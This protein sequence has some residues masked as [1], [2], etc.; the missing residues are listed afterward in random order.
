LRLDDW[1][2]PD[3][4]AEGPLQLAGE[5]FVLWY[6]V[7]LAALAARVGTPPVPL[8]GRGLIGVCVGRYGIRSEGAASERS[9]GDGMIELTVVA[10]VRGEQGPRLMALHRLVDTGLR[11]ETLRGLAFQRPREQACIQLEQEGAR[12]RGVAR[13][14]SGL[15]RLEIQ[16]EDEH[17]LNHLGAGAL[18]SLLVPTLR[19]R[20]PVGGGRARFQ[21]DPRSRFR[22]G[23]ARQVYL[24]ERL[25]Q[26]LLTTESMVHP[27][28]VMVS[29]QM[30]LTAFP[31]MDQHESP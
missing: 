19:G 1:R 30:H 7:D 27:I 31:G 11:S 18:L 5:G 16:V 15:E 8:M 3:L 12:W 14:R 13:C 2:A 17:W 21:L 22:L 6:R 4:S 23:A 9:A 20:W 10:L 26:G 28:A 29:S 25:H 24:P